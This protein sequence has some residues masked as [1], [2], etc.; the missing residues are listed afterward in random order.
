MDMTFALILSAFV[1]G[2]AAFL[3]FVARHYWRRFKKEGAGS[4]TFNY[5]I[6]D[7]W[8][9]TLA[10]TPTLL[11][12]SFLIKGIEARSLPPGDDY[13]FAMLVLFLGGGQLTGIFVGRICGDL[14][15]WGGRRTDWDSASLIVAAGFMGVFLPMIYVF[16]T[17][18]VGTVIFLMGLAPQAVFGI[19]LLIAIVRAIQGKHPPAK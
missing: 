18:I 12:L 4:K 2:Y 3:F 5:R 9:A 15:L 16:G 11:I 13:G 17:L 19:V 14:P 8:A 1:A 10:L 7:I 6:T